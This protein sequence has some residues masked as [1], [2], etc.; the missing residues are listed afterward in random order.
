MFQN[1]LFNGWY[2]THND[3][4]SNIYFQSHC[5]SGNI[6][7]LFFLLSYINHERNHQSA[8]RIE[9]KNDLLFENTEVIQYIS[10]RWRIANIYSHSKDVEK[11]KAKKKS[12][13][14]HKRETLGSL[15]IFELC[16]EEVF[17]AFARGDCPS[18][19]VVLPYLP[20]CSKYFW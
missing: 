1:L 16:S 15:G 20:M 17:D 19:L 18:G 10:H 4:W 9:M 14:V 8:W 5:C 6:L 13:E 2:A 3:K 11:K 12:N 7:F